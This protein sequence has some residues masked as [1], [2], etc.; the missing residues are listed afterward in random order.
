[1]TNLLYLLQQEEQLSIKGRD[2]LALA[3]QE[4]SRVSQIATQ[5]LRFHRQSTKPSLTRVE[6]VLEAVQALYKS[7]ILRCRAQMHT[8]FGPTPPILAFEGELRQLF[9]NLI[10]NALDAIPQGGQLFVRTR[11]AARRDGPRG[12]LV[13]VADTGQGIP[14]DLLGHIFEP[15]VTS[16]GNIGTGLGLWVSKEI[17][18]KHRGYMRVRS[19]SG[20][21]SGTVFQVFLADILAGPSAAGA[22]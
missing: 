16:K 22:N 11:P 7:R 21:L 4:L 1:V 3:E 12:I 6:D 10:S 9:A 18:E 8:R 5:T 13:T 19:R 14:P 20:P 2:Y 15:F 17:V